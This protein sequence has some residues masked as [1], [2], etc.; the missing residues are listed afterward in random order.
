MTTCIH[1]K[2]N[3]RKTTGAEIYPHRRDLR[4]KIIW[5]CDPCNAT[6]GCH[7][8]GDKPLGY[9]AN[10]KT[11]QARMKLHNLMLDPI[12]KNAEGPKGRNRSRVYKYLSHKMGIPRTETHTGMFTIEQCRDAWRALQGVTMEYIH[13]WREREKNG[14]GNIS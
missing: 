4:T 11:R 10:K 13:D 12:W 6:V 3:C 1:C 14:A 2:G 5:K 8:G 9:A 7:P